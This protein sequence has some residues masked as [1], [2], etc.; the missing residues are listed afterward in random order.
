[1]IGVQ[2]FGAYIPLY[3]LKRELMGKAWG[4]PSGPGERAVANADEDTVTM[5]VEAGLDCLQGIDPKTVDG[6]FFAST[7]APYKEKAAS[8]VIATTLDLPREALVQDFTDSL[9]AGTSAIRA[10]YDAIKAGSARRVLVIASEIR[11]AEQESVEEQSYG[12]A[13]AA[14][15]LSEEDVLAELK[16]FYSIQDEIVGVWRRDSDEYIQ[17]FE[18]KI[19]AKYGCQGNLVEAVKGLAKKTGA[20]IKEVSKLVSSYVAPRDPGAVAKKVGLDPKSQVQDPMFKSLGNTGTAQPL[21]GFAA[22]LE[23]AGSGDDIILAAHGDGAD[24]LLFTVTDRIGSFK[25]RLGVK[26]HLAKRRDL[27]SYDYYARNRKIIM[28][29]FKSPP[30]TPVVHL[31][32]REAELPFYGVKCKN[33]GQVQYPMVRLCYV[34]HTRDNFEKVRLSD[35]GTI[36]TFTRDYIRSGGAD[37]IPWCVISLEDGCRVFLTMTDCDPDEVKINMPVERTFRLIHQGA[38]F[39]NYYWKCRPREA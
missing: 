29:N 21:I 17:H 2:A 34:C 12:D 30:A 4:L 38:G 15:L 27:V 36:Y 11:L 35:R 6:L 9:R 26:G 25:P 32:E 7:S 37:P 22:A 20:E 16:D 10:A 18:D 8:T 23:D 28:K 1:M 39:N 33:C 3:R 19:D 13:A 31:R 5:A 14:V 24:A